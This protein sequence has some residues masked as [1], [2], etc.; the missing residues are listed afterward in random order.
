MPRSSVSA[1]LYLAFLILAAL[2][3]LGSLLAIGKTRQ[4][5]SLSAEFEAASQA[6]RYVEQVNG[7][8]YGVVMESRGVYMS[9]DIAAARRYAEG[10]SKLNDRIGAVVRFWGAAVGANDSGQFAAFSKRIDQFQEFRNEVARRGGEIGPAAAREW[11]D[12]DAN[13][14]VTI[15]LM[16]DI[17]DLAR[18][19]Q[20]RSDA[21]S[22]AMGEVA[23]E[24][25]WILAVLLV[26]TI[27]AAVGGM[28]MLRRTVAWPL[29]EIARV[30]QAVAAG[31]PDVAI[32]YRR[33]EDEIGALARSI[34]VFKDAMRRNH[35]L[36]RSVLAETEARAQHERQ[37]A[38]ARRESEA[39][40]VRQV[41]ERAAYTERIIGRFRMAAEN[42]LEGFGTETVTLSQTAGTLQGIAG[43]VRAQAKTATS[44]SEQTSANVKSV[45]DAAEELAGSI[46]EISRQLA[47]AT[48]VV[49][50]AGS[51]TKASAAQIEELA[52]T[53]Q[54]IGAVV[55]MIQAIA[56]QT[57][58]LALNATIEAARAGEAGKGFAVVAQEVKAL[59]A[60]TAKAT[61][62]IAQQIT[63]IQSSTQDAVGSVRLIGES[64]RQID[65]ATTAIAGAIE[66]QEATT[67]QMNQNLH[68][69][70]GGT[71]LLAANIGAMAGRTDVTNRSADEV[72]AASNRIQAQAGQL[73]EEFE[74]FFK[75][76]REGP[77]ERRSTD[78]PDYAGARRRK[79]E[80][81]AAA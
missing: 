45:S 29:S 60:Q 64:M 48:K 69:A 13:R 66:E 24:S 72:L 21:L 6:S 44:A 20:A 23:A 52:A 71:Q 22:A 54:R 79:S 16:E 32:P 8:I 35:E 49:Q 57:N 61:E 41:R 53:A 17:Q 4:F 55:Y 12:N 63:A 14:S 15:P 25:G 78:N 3:T 75:E 9:P 70:A 1:K 28:I 31:Q 76:L 59:A 38:E 81:S 2:V 36:N 58:L 18:V 65:E 51:N 77:G 39:E 26:A 30:T 80:R 50:L 42:I 74:R 27:M 40:Q 62:E 56:G 5:A 19:Y 43:Q 46:E 11:G 33:R 37:D 10:L 7:L 68:S 47:Q 67:R 73:T 34:E